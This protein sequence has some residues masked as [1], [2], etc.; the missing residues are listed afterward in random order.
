MTNRQILVDTLGWG[1]LLWFLGYVLGFI[2]FA[3]VPVNLV[4]WIILPIGTLLTLW[5]AFRRIKGPGLG[6][7][8]L[9]ALVWTAIAVIGDYLGIVKILNPPD[10]YYKPDVYLYYALTFLI[11]MA[12]G[13]VTRRRLAAP[14]PP[15]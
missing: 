11:P 12:A 9:V 14:S 7:Y 1:L 5:V 2:L 10:G 8:I 6:H 3:F 13:I 15:G 4:G